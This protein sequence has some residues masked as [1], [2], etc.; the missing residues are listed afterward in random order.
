MKKK[1]KI[2]SNT[3][4]FV[5]KEI[6]LI[7]GYKLTNETNES[8]GIIINDI[9][10]EMNMESTTGEELYRNIKDKFQPEKIR[11]KYVNTANYVYSEKEEDNIKYI[12]IKIL[13]NKNKPKDVKA[14]K[15]LIKKINKY[16]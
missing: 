14:K 8:E 5:Y 16:T 2:D 11:S 15:I 4:H 1:L 10:I 7:K 12:E 9:K 6:G 3:K 13:T